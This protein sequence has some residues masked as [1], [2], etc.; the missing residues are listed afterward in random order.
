MIISTFVQEH[1][2]TGIIYILINTKDKWIDYSIQ[3]CEDLGKIKFSHYY[4]VEIQ[5]GYL[6]DYEEVEYI[7]VKEGFNSY[8]YRL[9]H[10]QCKDQITIVC[11]PRE[12]IVN[13]ENWKKYY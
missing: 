3:N 8:N 7:M 1:L 6:D 12:F 11:I 2:G 5:P 10:S 4:T 13:K 9:F